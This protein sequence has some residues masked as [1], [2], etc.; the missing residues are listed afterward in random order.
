VLRRWCAATGEDLASTVFHTHA[1]ILFDEVDVNVQ[2][3]GGRP[4]AVEAVSAELHGRN[5]I[6]FPE[7]RPATVRRERLV[8]ALA[9][10]SEGSETEAPSLAEG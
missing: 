10:S 6:A 4:A 3:A 9:R 8:A 7:R 5:Q 2:L 1:V